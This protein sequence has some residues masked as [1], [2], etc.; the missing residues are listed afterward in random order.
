M[1]NQIDENIVKYSKELRLPVFR[2]DFKEL[3][4]EAAIQQLDY[5]EFLLRLMEREYELRAENRKKAQIRQACFP[6]KMYLSDLQREQLPVDAGEKLPLLERLDFIETGKN[7]VLAGNPGT[8]KTHIAVGLGLKACLQ[9][10]KVLFTSIHRLLTQLRES[11]SQRT[12]RQL[13]LKFEKYD[14]V[15]CDEFG[16]V[17]F[18]KQG[19]ELLFNHLSLRAGRKSTIITTNLSFDRWEEIFGDP[20]LTAALVDRLTHKAYLVNMNGES[21]RLK[22]TKQMNQK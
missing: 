10:Y 8:G 20:V 5:E 12:L 16:Y 21:Y 19:A 13:E 4:K 11:H 3:S 9:G 22:E 2:R 7:I 1:N 18:D 15:I 6:S 14:L 17:S